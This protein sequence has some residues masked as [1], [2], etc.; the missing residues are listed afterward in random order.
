[1]RE[2]RCPRWCDFSDQAGH[3]GLH[4]AHIG[5]VMLA[6]N[7]SVFAVAVTAEADAKRPYCVLTL[8]AR[9]FSPYG[10]AILSWEMAERLAGLLMDA[11]GRYGSWAG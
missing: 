7:A 3:S 5:E 1:M 8:A 11:K 4:T 10:K 2:R 9:Q 6:R